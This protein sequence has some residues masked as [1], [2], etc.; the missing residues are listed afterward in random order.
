SGTPA[1]RRFTLVTRA[2]AQT[3][4]KPR[5]DG[6]WVANVAMLDPTD[7]LTTRVVHQLLTTS[8]P[9]ERRA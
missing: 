7:W 1:F 2:T 5:T 4:L 6:S 8:T 3:T 9:N